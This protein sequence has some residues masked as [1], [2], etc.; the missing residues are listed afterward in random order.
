MEAANGESAIHVVNAW[1]CE[2]QMVLGHY[3]TDVKSN[4]PSRHAE[5]LA[6]FDDAAQSEAW[7]KLRSLIFV[8]S[9]RTRRGT[10]SRERRATISSCDEPASML[11]A[12]V[13]GHWH[14]ENK[15]HW[16]LDVTFGEDHAR[17]SRQ[18]GA[19]R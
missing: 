2:H 10:T 1:V 9:E 13:R 14:V 8:E 19:E 15:L 3:A 12:K 6:S 11:A 5:V 16:V 18:Y 7:P 4:Q 17:I